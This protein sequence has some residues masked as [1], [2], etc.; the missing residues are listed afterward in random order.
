MANQ[1]YR[2]NPG[3]DMDETQVYRGG[4]V[5]D[6]D[7]GGYAAQR[8]PMTAAPGTTMTTAR[9]MTGAIMPRTMSRTM[10]QAMTRTMIQTIIRGMR[11]VTDRGTIPVMTR[12]TKTAMIPAA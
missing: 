3:D 12:V 2:R 9:A 7:A 1:G 4:F 6:R 11:R 5:P 10:T 8:G